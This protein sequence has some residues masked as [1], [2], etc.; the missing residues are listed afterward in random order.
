MTANHQCRGSETELIVDMQLK[1]A[2]C[3]TVSVLA[4]IAGVGMLEY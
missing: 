4:Y 2:T 1:M 3:I